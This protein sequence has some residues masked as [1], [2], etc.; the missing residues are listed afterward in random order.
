[1]NLFQARPIS[2]GNTL[3]RL[4]RPVKVVSFS[5]KADTLKVRGD[6]GITREYHLDGKPVEGGHVELF[7]QDPVVLIP[8]D[9]K[10]KAKQKYWAY[11]KK[12]TLRLYH[13]LQQE[14]P[15]NG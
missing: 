6:D 13:I 12:E 10:D 3:Y 15:T 2:I 11:A 5:R 8:P 7:W 4:R 9:P 1:M 14:F